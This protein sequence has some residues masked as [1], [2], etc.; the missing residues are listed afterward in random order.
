MAA[1]A[2]RIV[3]EAEQTG[4]EARAEAAARLEKV[5]VDRAARG[6]RRR[7]D[8]AAGHRGG[9]RGAAAG[10]GRV[11]PDAEHRTGG[12]PSGGRR[13]GRDPGPT[14]SRR[15]DA[16]C[17]APRG[18]GGPRGPAILAPGRGRTVGPT[19]RRDDRRPAGGPPRLDPRPAPVVVPVPAGALTT[20]RLKAAAQGGTGRPFLWFADRGVMEACEELSFMDPGTSASRS[21]R[22]PSSSNPPTPSSA[23]SPPASAARTCGATA[24]SRRSRG[25]RRSGTS[26]SGS[27][28][29]WAT[30]SRPCR[31]GDFVVGG[32]LHSDNTCPVCRKGMHANCQHGGGFDG[33]QAEKIRIPN[34]DGTLIAT[35]G[36]PDAD[37]IPSLLALSDVMC[38]GWHAAV[39]AGVR[40]GYER[41]RRRRRRRRAQR[42]PRRGPARRDDDHRHEPARV[43]P[44]GGQ[45]VRRHPRRRRARRGGP[46]P[47]AR[48]DRRHRRGR[49]AGVRRHRGGPRPGGRATPVPAA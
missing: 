3:E 26:T 25:R 38:T 13:G 32:F 34:A 49:G 17:R 29:R 5:L 11:R 20:P 39:S 19:G 45:G 24:A 40:P 42:C 33:C 28:S 47:G 14:R 44:A 12:A 2:G 27:S 4:R 48:A 8:P 16:P 7:A 31:P 21:G 23:P 41:R 1:E 46:G 22:T 10:P 15:L 43:A 37:L 6:R 9:S 30:P 18:G 35:P 36:Q